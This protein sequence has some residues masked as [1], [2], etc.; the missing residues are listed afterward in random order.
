MPDAT[1]RRRTSRKQSSN[2]SL[3]SFNPRTGEVMAEIPTT[4]PAEVKEVVERG[5]K[6]QP[7]W[8]AIAPEG[9][10]HIMREVRYRIYDLMDKIVDTVSAE[11]GKP[12]AEALA[13]DVMPP[14]ILLTGY[15]QIAPRV[16][17]SKKV[18]IL[19]PP[20]LPKLLGGAVS[21]IDLK[22]FGVVGAITPWNYPITNC[23]LAFAPALFAG[24]TVVIKPS[25][26]TPACGE[27][28]REIL[29]PLPPGVAQ[30]IQGGGEVGAALVDAP[31]DKISFI[32]S[33]PTGRKI[34]E[35]A[36]KHLT[37]V[38]MELGGKDAAIVLD[39]ADL[40]IASSGIVWGSFFNAGQTC[41]SIERVYVADSIADEF[42]D[43]MLT[44]LQKVEQGEQVGSLT[45]K[46]QLGIVESQV[47][48]ALGKGAKLLAGGPDAGLK[49]EKGS[50]WYAPTVLES[51]ND[52]M[53]V[54]KNETFGPVVTITRVQDEAEAIRRANE[55]AVN[56]TASI[57][58][59]D[60]KRALKVAHE[61][62]A[63]NVS[64]NQHGENPASVWGAWGGFGE[65]GFGR[66]NGEYGLRE[67]TVPV[68]V[69]RTQMKMKRLW[70][71]PYDDASRTV[72]RSTV[73]AF[74]ARTAGE[75][76]KGLGGVLG[77]AAK[78]LKNKI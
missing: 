24:N 64:I 48:D 6:V 69:Q 41:C 37:P 27:L 32:G 76:L 65:S 53:D 67:F 15:E 66:L 50:L 40:D 10:A 34:C 16:L 2:G 60:S 18:G 63:G 8:A 72:F 55:E 42:K 11:C 17:K 47:K 35:A 43:R 19:S 78:A 75:R 61:L 71:Y 39:D 46:N 68:F 49:N 57:W 52:E 23:F 44:K 77:G 28:I 73:Q 62:K 33:P 5:R 54:M 29:E 56:L 30:V 4:S 21:H 31:V 74:A 12:S 51:V 45:F 3:K 58:T 38:V 20:I 7:E 26:V 59:N 1:T 9:R 14:V 22:P 25:E 36:S 13:H 70:W